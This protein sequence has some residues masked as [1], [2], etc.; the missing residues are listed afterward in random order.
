MD[1]ERQRRDPQLHEQEASAEYW[2]A[3]ADCL[4]EIVCQLLMK[5]QT[6]RFE[7]I[8]SE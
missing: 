8:A 7:Q 5:I 6:M 3:K 1:T 2:R 4:Q